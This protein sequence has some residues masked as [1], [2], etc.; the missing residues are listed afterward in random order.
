MITSMTG[1]ASAKG[2]LAPYNWAW[3]LRS[4]NAKGEISGCASPIGGRGVKQ[5]GGRK[6]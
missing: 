5:R 6:P 1:F 2:T 4:V 3:E